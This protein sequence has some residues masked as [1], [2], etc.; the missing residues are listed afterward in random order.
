MLKRELRET[1]E[2]A[3]MYKMTLKARVERSKEEA[4]RS[5]DLARQ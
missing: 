5:L 4:R 2:A 3:F 1:G